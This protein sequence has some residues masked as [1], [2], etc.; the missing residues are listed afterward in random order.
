MKDQQEVTLT[1]PLPA[2]NLCLNALQVAAQ[3]F[4]ATAIALTN[5]A[6]KSLSVHKAPEPAASAPVV[7][8]RIE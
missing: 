4:E 7:D 3:A 6:N 1:L 8:A 2:V 5:E